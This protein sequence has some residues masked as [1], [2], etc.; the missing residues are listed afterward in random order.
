MEFFVI[1]T[2]VAAALTELFALIP[3][4]YTRAL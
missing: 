4:K 1:A 2:E 3:I